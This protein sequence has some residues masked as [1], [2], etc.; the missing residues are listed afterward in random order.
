MQTSKRTAVPLTSQNF[1]ECG[2][3][4][5]APNRVPDVQSAYVS[6]WDQAIDFEIDGKIDVGFLEL[7]P[8]PFL[9]T[10]MERHQTHTQS[11]IPLEGAGLILAVAPPT[12]ED[13]PKIE[14]IRA[15][16][17]D[18]SC[19]V[20]LHRGVWHDILYPVERPARVISILRQG[21]SLDD[22]FIVDLVEAY[23]TQISIELPAEQ[24]P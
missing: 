4:I 2:Q 18:G 11:F 14:T 15:Y 9:L 10:K 3:L 6:F 13:R 7:R 8:R 21:T 17:L 16:Y 1:A 19:G 12:R 22:M 23:N 20:M 24:T 5:I